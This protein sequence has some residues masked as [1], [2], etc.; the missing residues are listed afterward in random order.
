MRQIFGAIAE[1]EKKMIIA[2]LRGARRRAKAKSGRRKPFSDR[3]GESDV[4][5]R[6]T[7]LRANGISFDGIAQQL[8]AEG[9][10]PRAGQ[11]W[12]P[13]AV[14]NILSRAEAR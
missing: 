11:R 13:S 3:P 10:R 4:L 7:E 8:N 5:Q 6:M 14:N 2:K 12:W 9:I 1:Y